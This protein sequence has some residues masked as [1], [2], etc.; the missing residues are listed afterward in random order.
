MKKDIKKYILC[1]VIFCVVLVTLVFVKRG[2][3]K[4]SIDNYPVIHETKF[5]GVYIKMTIDDF[6]ELGFKFGDSVDVK[7]S[8]GYELLDLPYYNGYYV[9][10]DEAL[11]IGYPG[12]DY[13]KVAVNYGDDL[14]LT[15]KLNENDT[16]SVILNEKEKYL[17]I[18]NASDIHYPET[19]GDISDIVF[20]NYRNVKVGNIK[21]GILYRSASPIDNSHNRA[22]VVDRLI[23]N[24]RIKYVVNLSDNEEDL[25]NH[26]NKEDFNSPY[27]KTLYD[28]KKYIAL[29]MNMQIK[30]QSFKDGLVKGLTAI[31]NNNGPYLVHCVEGKDR[32]GYF[33]LILE[34]LL[35]SSYQEM[36]DDYM[37]TYENYYGITKENDKEKYETIKVRNIDM[38]LH[39]IVGSDNI[40][41][42]KIDDYSL[43]TKNYLLSIGMKEEDINKLINRLK[44][45]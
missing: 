9:D 24:D 17:N 2:N 5:G 1:L 44:L 37:K 19:Q 8:N 28:S 23:S 10:I 38:M 42:T 12:Y 16:A 6:N 7:F 25:V 32:T 36:L 26:F 45:E 27:F 30:E 31:S 4:L 39:Y 15:A 20:A 33:I 21:E 35:G 11:L 22:S 43:Y 40:D 3:K 34:S 29:G 13:I 41:L 18:Q 14:W